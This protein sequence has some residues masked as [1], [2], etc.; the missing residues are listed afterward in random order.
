[1]S[2]VLEDEHRYAFHLLTSWRNLRC[3]SRL[4]ASEWPPFTAIHD[5]VITNQSPE[6]IRQATTAMMTT[7]LGHCQDCR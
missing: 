1:V 3:L 6:L 2:G 4:F 7:P 5:L